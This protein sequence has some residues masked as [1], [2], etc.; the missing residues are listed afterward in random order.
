MVDKNSMLFAPNN[1]EDVC[2]YEIARIL[3]SGYDY[4]APVFE[5]AR[6]HRDQRTGGRWFDSRLL[7]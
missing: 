3:A 6:G 2:R 5:T 7:V 1:V 4:I